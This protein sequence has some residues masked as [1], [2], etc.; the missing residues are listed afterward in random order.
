MTDGSD[1]NS[2]PKLADISATC[3]PVRVTGVVN[4]ESPPGVTI[5]DV[6]KVRTLFAA[7]NRGAV[8]MMLYNLTGQEY[9]LLDA[10]ITTYSGIFGGG[11][12]RSNYLIKTEHQ[13]TYQSTLDVFSRDIMKRMINLVEESVK[14]GKKGYVKPSRFL[15]EGD[16]P[17]WQMNGLADQFPGHA[18]FFEIGTYGPENFPRVFAPGTMYT[19]R[20]VSETPFTYGKRPAEF[21]ANQDFETYTSSDNRFI[22]VTHKKTCKVEVFFDTKAKAVVKSQQR[23]VAPVLWGPEWHDRL[24]MWEFM[25]GNQPDYNPQNIFVWNGNKPVGNPNRVGTYSRNLSNGNWYNGEET[26]KVMDANIL[27]DLER[28]RLEIIAVRKGHHLPDEPP[29]PERYLKAQK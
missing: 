10:Q 5:E 20:A 27:K 1:T 17:V 7:G 26:V 14:Q 29:I 22:T 11:A 15:L 28:Q 13:S 9:W 16:G 6:E 25:Q 8:Y 2:T 24:T 19:Y 23:N 21:A 12:L 3:T 18:L 4:P